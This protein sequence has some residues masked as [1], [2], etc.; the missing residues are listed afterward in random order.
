VTRIARGGVRHVVQRPGSAGYEIIYS[1]YPSVA[2]ASIRGV[3]RR[4][5][6]SATNA[7]DAVRAQVERTFGSGA[8]G[9]AGA[10]PRPRRTRARFSPRARQVLGLSLREASAL[11]HRAIGTE[12]ILLGI[13][14]DGGGLAAKVLHDPGIN[15]A[16]LRRRLPAR[17][18]HAA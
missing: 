12:H 1:Q 8:L 10:R 5:I 16:D 14:R 7:L 9:P 15:L 11:R 4:L 6:A 3:P 18:P 17:L 2:H 13:L